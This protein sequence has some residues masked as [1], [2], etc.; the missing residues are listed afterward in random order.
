MSELVLEC[1]I[2]EWSVEELR[3][4]LFFCDRQCIYPEAW[5]LHPQDQQSL[6]E[7]PDPPAWERSANT[8]TLFHLPLQTTL[9]QSHLMCLRGSGATRPRQPVMV[10]LFRVYPT[11]AAA[12][13]IRE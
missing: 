4:V 1:A 3:R 7:N 5:R 8:E 12:A 9:G 2:K 13:E 6:R 10:V 11:G